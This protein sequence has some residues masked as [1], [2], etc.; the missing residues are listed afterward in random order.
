MYSTI[1][2]AWESICT[3]QVM[4][5]LLHVQACLQIIQLLYSFIVNNTQFSNIMI[6]VFIGV[7]GKEFLS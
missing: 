1:H 2:T 6:T 7:L 3:E 4:I 5:Y